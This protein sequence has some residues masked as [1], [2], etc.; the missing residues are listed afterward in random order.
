MGV[1]CNTYGKTP[2]DITDKNATCRVLPLDVWLEEAD[3]DIIDKSGA[4]EGDRACVI[5]GDV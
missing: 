2:G 5:G 4:A 1:T 3:H